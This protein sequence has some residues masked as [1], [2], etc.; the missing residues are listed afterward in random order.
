MIVS[1]FDLNDCK[2]CILDVENESMLNFWRKVLEKRTLP[3]TNTTKNINILDP[4]YDGPL[5]GFVAKIEGF[6]KYFIILLLCF[7]K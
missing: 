2:H 1:N 4:R 5:S 3:N 7:S 6:F